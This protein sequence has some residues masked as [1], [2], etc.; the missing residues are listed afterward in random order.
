MRAFSGL[1]PVELTA[2]DLGLEFVFVWHF[3]FVVLLSDVYP[4]AEI[5][6]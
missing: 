4:L 3:Y 5:F 6:I 2:E 1:L